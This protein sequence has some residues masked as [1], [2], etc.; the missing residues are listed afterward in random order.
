MATML[1]DRPCSTGYVM[2]CGGKTEQ[3]N[4]DGLCGVAGQNFPGLQHHLG[5]AQRALARRGGVF[6]VGHHLQHDG[7]TGADVQLVAHS[8][9]DQT[10]P[11]AGE[12]QLGPA[13]GR[14]IRPRTGQLHST[15]GT[16]RR[17]TRLMPSQPMT[18]L[19]VVNVPSANDNM[20]PSPP[21]ESST[22]TSDLRKDSA[23]GMSLVIS[24][25]NH[26]RWRLGPVRCAFLVTQIE[27]QVV[28]LA[29]VQRDATTK[30]EERI[31]STGADCNVCLES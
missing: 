8:W 25:N 1:T 30:G 11:R 27:Q 19:Q 21:A 23:S 12:Y 26:A 15:R 9:P 5:V 3:W 4:G 22:L 24:V 7:L 28:I 2:M 17:V 14:H 13:Y 20:T 18:R 31:W 29:V 16:Y 10:R 6:E